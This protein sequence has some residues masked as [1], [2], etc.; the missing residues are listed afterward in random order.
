[1]LKST[2]NI[3]EKIDIGKFCKLTAFLKKKHVG[4]VAKKSSVFTRE[5]INKFLSEAS[6]DEF[7]LTKVSFSVCFCNLKCRLLKYFCFSCRLL[8]LLVLLVDAGA[9]SW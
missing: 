5:D 6:D 7:L 3:Y 4:Y 1:M 2:M 9:M 8:L